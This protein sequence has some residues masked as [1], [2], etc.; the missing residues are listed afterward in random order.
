MS[1]IP[2]PLSLFQTPTSTVIPP[3]PLWLYKYL[4]AF[5]VTGFFGLDHFALGS[6]MTGMLKLF[7]NMITL[8]S[9][10][11][12]DV[13]QVYHGQ[14]LRDGLKIPFLESGAIGK[15]RIDDTPMGIMTKNTKLWILV[16]FIS[17][18][19]GLYFITTFFVSENTDFMST[20][21]RNISKLSFYG[22]L[23]LILG[24]FIFFISAKS[25]SLF[26][27]IPKGPGAVSSLL[28]T[29][30]SVPILGNVTKKVSGFGPSLLSGLPGLSGGGDIEEMTNIAKEVL[31]G[32]K[33]SET[34]DHILFPFILL[35]LPVSGFIIYT[36]RK[37]GKKN[38]TS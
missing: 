24:T 19:G 25:S 27:A 35:L 3:F 38:E 12:Y 36:L 13:V 28:A 23:A 17:L 6:Q 4:A 34:Y 8:G 2:K 33:V 9:W 1:V 16:I 10:Y 37:G 21:I 18:F 22:T 7:V 29:S 26:P 20:I 31:Q 30:G 11:A 32:G 5:P 15:G 14:H